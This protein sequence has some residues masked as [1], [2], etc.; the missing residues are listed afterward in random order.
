MGKKKWDNKELLI[1]VTGSIAVGFLL[2]MNFV[3][4]TLP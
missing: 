1:F 2:G 4:R 3:I